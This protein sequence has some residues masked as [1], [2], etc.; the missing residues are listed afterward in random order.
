MGCF[1]WDQHIKSVAQ[2]ALEELEAQER[3]SPQQ[4]P[5]FMRGQNGRLPRSL[6]VRRSTQAEIE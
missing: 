6:L 3:C 5:I 4:G 1:R 2:D